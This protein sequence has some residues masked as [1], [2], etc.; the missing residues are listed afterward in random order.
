MAG[1]GI[2]ATGGTAPTTAPSSRLGESHDIESTSG[3]TFPG[4]VRV[5]GPAATGHR[6][7]GRGRGAHLR[8]SVRRGRPRSGDGPGPGPRAGQPTTRLPPTDR[9]SGL[10]RRPAEPDRGR[11][12]GGTR[13]IGV[14]GPPARGPHRPVPD[15]RRGGHGAGRPGGPPHGAFPGGF[16]PAGGD[17]GVPAK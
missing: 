14:G 9:G 1:A 10:L 3:R 12:G 6:R 5:V 2:I 7:P 16:T 11:L 15:P 4:G 8:P 17:P 13:P